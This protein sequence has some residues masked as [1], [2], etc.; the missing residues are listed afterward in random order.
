MTQCLAIAK[1]TV[2]WASQ[3]R[4]TNYVEFESTSQLGVGNRTL[5]G[6]SFFVLA[7]INTLQKGLVRWD[8][9]PDLQYY[10]QPVPVGA[11]LLDIIDAI[12][13]VA[14]ASAFPGGK[15]TYVVTLG[16]HNFEARL[17]TLRHLADHGLMLEVEAQHGYHRFMFTKLG[18]Q[19]LR[20]CRRCIKPN[21][22]FK[23]SM[24]GS[25]AADKQDWSMYQILSDLLAD[26]WTCQYPPR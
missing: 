10:L 3:D 25:A 1:H 22:L 13:P 6:P 7:G 15:S 8:L 12:T 20:L 2:V 5:L 26:G 9:E 23:G 17:R 11:K 19:S 21:S 16:S 14:Q 24:D 18:V 4:Q